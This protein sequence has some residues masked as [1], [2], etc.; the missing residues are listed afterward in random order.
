MTH[1]MWRRYRGVALALLLSATTGCVTRLPVAT[2][3]EDVPDA[4][5]AD[6]VPAKPADDAPSG[7]PDRTAEM[8]RLRPGLVIGFSMLVAGKAEFPESIKQVSDTG[9]LVLPLLGKVKVDGLTL[10]ELSAELTARYNRF[11]VDPQVILEFVRNGTGEGVSPWG[12]VTVLGRV[13]SPGRIAIPATRDLTV[14]GAIQKA[15]GFQSSARSDAILVTRRSAR[16][17]T[18][19]RPVNLNAV[20]AGGRVEDDLLLQ[21]EDVV[22]VPETRF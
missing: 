20:G 8:A 9:T 21:A 17:E 10:E 7:L 11:F 14:S 15:G 12:F 19:T 6:S 18:T 5:P 3:A 13:K 2:V 1:T 16:G 4:V 22:F